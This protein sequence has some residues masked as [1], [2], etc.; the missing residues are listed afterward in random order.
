MGVPAMGRPKRRGRE[1][2]LP[3]R[4]EECCGAGEEPAH[5]GAAEECEGNQDR[6][7]QC[8]AAKSRPPTMAAM[9]GLG[10]R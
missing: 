6:V 9:L 3:R 5:G 2:G 1:D 4:E 10:M 8:S 7:G